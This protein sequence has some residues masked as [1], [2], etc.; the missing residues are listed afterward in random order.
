MTTTAPT[1]TATDTDRPTTHELIARAEALVAVLRERAREAEQLRRIPDETMADL[2]VAG[3]LYVVSPR[4]EGYGLR[5]TSPHPT[6]QA[7]HPPHKPSTACAADARH[8]RSD[9]R[10]VPSTLVRGAGELHRRPRTER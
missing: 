3:L 2:E 6:A 7:Q 9:T 10:H 1:P 5:L 8:V 4:S